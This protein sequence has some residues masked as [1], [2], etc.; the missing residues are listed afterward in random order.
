[1]LVCIG[2]TWRKMTVEKLTLKQL[3]SHLWESGLAKLHFKA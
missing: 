2:S 1:M 3:E